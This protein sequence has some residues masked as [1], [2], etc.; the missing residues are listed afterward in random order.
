MFDVYCPTHGARIL[1]GPRSIE[2]LENVTHGVHVLWRCYC[3]TGGVLRI[4][5]G[6]DLEPAVAA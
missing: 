1:L 5:D 3:G 6:H 4:V 2:R